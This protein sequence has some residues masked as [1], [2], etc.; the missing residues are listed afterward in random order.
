[1]KRHGAVVERGKYLPRRRYIKSHA[2]VV[3]THQIIYIFNSLI[4]YILAHII[5][6]KRN[7]SNIRPVAIRVEFAKKIVGR[8]VAV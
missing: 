6:G 8:Y 1:M 2:K 7:K 4:D 3:V 5:L